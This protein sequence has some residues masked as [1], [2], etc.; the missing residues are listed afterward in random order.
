MKN[1]IGPIALLGTSADPPTFGHQALLQGLLKLFP[2]VVT[3][4]SDNPMKCHGATLEERHALLQVLVKT[5]QSE[6]LE[7]VQEL[8]SPWTFMTLEKANSLWPQNKLVFVIGSDLIKDVPNWIK[9][10]EFLQKTSLG[11][12]PRE[13]WPINKSDVNKIKS[14]GGKIDL[15]PLKIP[16]ASSSEARSNPKIQKIPSAVFSIL[17]EQNLYGLKTINQ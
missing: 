8:S 7:L 11:I 4:A 12:A 5:I 13:G 10:N 9:A 1:Q 16:S 6:N 2:R 3:W 17:L 15:L 14:L